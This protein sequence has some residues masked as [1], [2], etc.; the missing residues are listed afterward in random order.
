[1][2]NVAQPIQQFIDNLSLNWQREVCQSLL[3]LQQ[4]VEPSV[5]GAI[6]W[7]N[8]YFS[9]NGQALLKWYCAKE[10]INVYF[11]KGIQLDDP[12]H[13]FE[14]TDNKAMRTIKLFVDTKLNTEAY[15][16]LVKE[17]VELNL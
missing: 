14:D 8:P 2:S 13:L 5:E 10:W 12:H 17:A 9:Y 16:E 11:F 15:K 7:Q 1:M 6:K 3:E 4:S